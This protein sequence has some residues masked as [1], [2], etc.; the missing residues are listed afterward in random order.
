MPLIT[1][2]S[3]QAFQK[4]IKSE[5]GAGKPLNQA[6]A[7]AYSKKREAE[8]R[9]KMWAGGEVEPMH[10]EGGMVDGMPEEPAVATAHQDDPEKGVEPE[11]YAAGGEVGMSM[12]DFHIHEQPSPY[13]DTRPLGH[14]VEMPA[15]SPAMKAHYDERDGIELARRLKKERR[16]F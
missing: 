8:H 3:K 5:V 7:I 16:Y 14:S 1:G 6:L 4:N 15:F 12:P 10:A 13:E 9:R 11:K 2:K